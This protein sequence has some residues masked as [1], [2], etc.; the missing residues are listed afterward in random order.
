MTID[1][2]KTAGVAVPPKAAPVVATK[3]EKPFVTTVEGKDLNIIDVSVNAPVN[4]MAQPQPIKS[5]SDEQKANQ[6]KLSGAATIGVTTDGRPVSDETTQDGR[7][8]VTGANVKVPSAAQPLEVRVEVPPGMEHLADGKE[9]IAYAT[10]NVSDKTIARGVTVA[11][12]MGSM[13]L[14]E[15]QAAGRESL[16]RKHGVNQLKNENEAGRKSASRVG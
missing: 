12:P 10:I 11:E 8:I 6:E 1:E 3:A 14:A 4:P 7:P 5:L 2:T 13:R 9:Q 15:E 16:E